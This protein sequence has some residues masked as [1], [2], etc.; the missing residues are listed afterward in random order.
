MRAAPAP[1]QGLPKMFA[2]TPRKAA[3]VKTGPGDALGRT[4]AAE[5]DFFFHVAT[6]DHTFLEEG[7]DD[8]PT[9]EDKR[10]GAV[11]SSEGAIASH[12]DEEEGEEDKEGKPAEEA[13]SGGFFFL[14]LFTGGEGED[15]RKSGEG[16]HD[17]GD[18]RGGEKPESDEDEEGDDEAAEIGREGAAHAEPGSGD[19]GEG[20]EL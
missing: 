10:T 2:L 16:D 13:A 17:D 8:V 12:G 5:E 11:D 19:D 6:I 9:T 18:P 3:K 15:T 4:V 20:Y 1:S 14:D 7:E